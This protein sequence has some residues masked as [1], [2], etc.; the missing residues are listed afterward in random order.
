MII[1]VFITVLLRIHRFY[2]SG[3]HQGKQWESLTQLNCC[4]WQTPLLFFFLAEIYG[5]R[6]MYP[7]LF[8]YIKSYW[9]GERMGKLSKS[10]LMS[11]H[12]NERERKQLSVL[13]QQIQFASGD[14]ILSFHFDISSNNHKQT[15]DFCFSF[16]FDS[17]FNLNIIIA[18]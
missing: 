16:G 10:Y 2:I 15:F 12:S 11:S 14:F 13:Y 17:L 8:L 3:R 7:V 1:L 6:K 5:D 9:K 18:I 4:S